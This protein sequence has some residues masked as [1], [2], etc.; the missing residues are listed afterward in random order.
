MK[1]E[2]VQIIEAP[3]VL[4]TSEEVDALASQLWITFPEGYREYMTR[5]GEGI[6]GL[7]VRIY[8]PWKVG[9]ELVSWRRRINRYWFWGDL[10]PKARAVECVVIGDTMGGDELIFHPSRPDRLFVLP[11]ES[12]QILEVGN[13]LLSAIDWC[14]SSGELAEPFDERDFEPFNTRKKNAE[15]VTGLV[16]DADDESLDDIIELGNRW[17]ERHGAIELGLKDLRDQVG[18]DKSYV[19]DAHLP[20]ARGYSAVWRVI[21]P[22]SKAELGVFHWNMSD[23][24]RG[25]WHDASV[26]QN[27]IPA[28][29]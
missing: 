17:T 21:H 22:I 15:N 18:L 26:K 12:E 5:L 2:D 24:T 27:S 13:D 3:L 1:I 25:W 28:S 14:C 10:L 6:L 4:A 11:H 20:Y 8:P 16:D 19:I 9:N 29:R 7:L 23:G